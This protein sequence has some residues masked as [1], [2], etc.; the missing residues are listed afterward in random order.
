[1]FQASSNIGK[2][3]LIGRFVLIIGSILEIILFPAFKNFLWCLLFLYSWFLF[4]K[5][6]FKNEN[7][8]RYLLPTLAVSGNILMYA[9]LPLIVTLI[10]I[11]PVTFN[12]EV[13]FDL[14]AYQAINITV[15]IAA[16]ALCISVYKPDNILVKV[17]AKIGFF[18]PPTDKQI[19]TF[20]FICLGVFIFNSLTFSEA[21]DGIDG[22]V[23]S[24]EGGGIASAF[25]GLFKTCLLI[26]VCLFFKNFYGSYEKRDNKVLF[27]AFFF[28]I[29]I[30]SIITTRR[31]YIF[32]GALVFFI[33]YC[34]KNIVFSNR[35]FVNAKR[36][37]LLLAAFFVIGGPVSNLAIAMAVVRNMG[38]THSLRQVLDLYNDK[39]KMYAIKQI[40]TASN[41]VGG[42]K[43]GWSE[44]YV[45]NAL[46]DRFCNLR[47]QDATLFYAE[48]LGFDNPVMHK[49]MEDRLST[50]VPGVLA[51]LGGLEKR[52]ESTPADLM[53]SEY[54]F[55][56]LVRYAGNKVTGHL[57]AGL[58][59]LGFKYYPVAFV[60][61]FALFY[62]F[63][64]CVY[65]KN[66]QLI[67]PVIVLCQ[68]KLY[69]MWFV[70]G[71]GIITSLETILRNGVQLI[72]F[73]CLVMFLV[74]KLVR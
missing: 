12:F 31:R 4:E 18:T 33:L 46:L 28:V 20:A 63:C 51:N 10:E 43:N 13:P 68:M 73:Y 59:W 62:F 42:N 45:D 52:G 56:G 70:N 55:S 38:E 27:L 54:V 47:V 22:V 19:W 30:C 49:Y 71:Y 23:A 58:Y 7:F 3:K 67:I 69:F 32:E 21:V 37:L 1:M 41:E 26:P 66:A 36:M 48:K 35:Q 11:K 61:Y 6:V 29:V 8:K 50:L 34:L 5:F 53:E 60:I 44:Y 15:I 74:K 40:Y 2:I 16:Y 64:S 17:W 39:E 25:Q 9:F 65:T 72:V 57:G 24:A 14:C